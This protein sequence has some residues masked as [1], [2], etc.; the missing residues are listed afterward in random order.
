[1]S[2]I[3]TLFALCTFSAIVAVYAGIKNQEQERMHRREEESLNAKLWS[4]PK[5]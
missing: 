2:L 5:K 4:G 1:M 3:W